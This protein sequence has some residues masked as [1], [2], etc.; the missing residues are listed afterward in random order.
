MAETVPLNVKWNKESF[1]VDLVVA[2]GVKGLKD[3]LEEKT[4]VPADRM[5]LMAKSKGERCFHINL[6]FS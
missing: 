6:G 2:D 1:K 3:A 5:K 4:G